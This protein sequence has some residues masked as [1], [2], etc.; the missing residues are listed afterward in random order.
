LTQ[1]GTLLEQQSNTCLTYS[2]EFCKLQDRFWSQPQRL[3]MYNTRCLSSQKNSTACWCIVLLEN[4]KVWKLFKRRKNLSDAARRDNSVGCFFT[5][6][7]TN[8][9][10]VRLKKQPKLLAAFAS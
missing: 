9:V 1:D 10:S 2:V 8:C 6:R 7:S 3:E 5:Q 4:V